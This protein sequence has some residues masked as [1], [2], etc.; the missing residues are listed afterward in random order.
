MVVE[1]KIHWI[2]KTKFDLFLYI[3]N[4]QLLLNSNASC[5]RLL[6]HM[7]QAIGIHPDG[8]RLLNN[9]Q[10]FILFVFLNR[11]NRSDG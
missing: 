4:Q 10:F 6:D 11:N 5:L 2:L 8:K 9:N 1:E 3:E 7:K